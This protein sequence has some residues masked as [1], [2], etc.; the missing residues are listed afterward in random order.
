MKITTERLIIRPFKTSDAND[1]YEIYSDHETCLYLLHQPW[2]D[3]N[4]ESEFN[5]K[6]AANK[7]TKDHAIN[8]ACQLDNKVIGDISIMYTAMKDTVEIGYAFNKAYANKGYA[9]EAMKSIVAYLF[10]E[11]KIHR[12]QACLDCRNIASAKLCQKI[13][14]R[15]EAHFIKDY[16]NKDEWTDSYVYGMLESDFRKT[17]SLKNN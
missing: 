2:N 6:L 3:A 5:K 10:N 14:M 17:L 13:G 4:K 7:L 12:I 11:L 15:Q 16:W 9:S 1:V 8:L